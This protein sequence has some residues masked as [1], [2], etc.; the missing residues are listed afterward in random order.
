M[1][2]KHAKGEERGEKK[3][4]TMNKKSSKDRSDG[5]QLKIR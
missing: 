5:W 3:R 2:D 4:E 1:R